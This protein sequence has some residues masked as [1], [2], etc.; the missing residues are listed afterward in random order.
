MSKPNIILIVAE[1]QGWNHFGYAGDPFARTPNLDG[2]AAHGVQFSQASTCSLDVEEA[3]ASLFTGVYRD[4]AFHLGRSLRSRGYSS[5]FVGASSGDIHR[6]FEIA[7]LTDHGESSAET[8]EYAQYLRGVGMERPAELDPTLGSYRS[9]L[10]ADHHPIVWIGNQAVRCVQQMAS[11]FFLI[12][13]IPRPTV[14]YDPPTPWDSQCAVTSTSHD[15]AHERAMTHYYGLGSLIDHQLGRVMATLSA[16]GISKTVIAY[17]ALHGDRIGG[18][19]GI[20][21]DPQDVVDAD[22]RVP[23]LIG[24]APMQRRGVALDTSVEIVDMVP[25]LLSLAGGT[26]PSVMQGASLAE[27][28]MRPGRGPREG[29]LVMLP[30]GGMAWRDEK[31]LLVCDAEGAP[32]RYLPAQGLDAPMSAVGGTMPAAVLLRARRLAATRERVG[33]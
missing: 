7:R 31:G 2:L 1:G 21:I 29:A 8:S 25:T 12:M 4:G 11:P 5:A 27:L 17:T 32:E 10:P 14:P 22:I 19:D 3:R 28:L 24:G 33:L 18:G 30:E 6:D 23:F 15:A 26:L 9:P 20:G 16:R 13:S